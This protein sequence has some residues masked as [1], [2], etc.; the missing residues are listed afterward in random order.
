MVGL[1]DVQAGPK[2]VTYRPWVRLSNRIRFNPIEDPADAWRV[3]EHCIA[4]E[5]DPDFATSTEGDCFVK[6]VTVTK[7]EMRIC[8]GH[9]KTPAEA[10][11]AAVRVLGELCKP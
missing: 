1:T 6:L 9:G 2:N 10:L 8:D 5:V 11:C 3:L 7:D 4:Q